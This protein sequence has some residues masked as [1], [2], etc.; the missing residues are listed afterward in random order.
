MKFDIGT[1]LMIG[2]VGLAAFFIYNLVTNCSGAG[3]LGGFGKNICT[4]LHGLIFQNQAEIKAGLDNIQ[5][6]PNQTA[7]LRTASGAHM[8]RLMSYN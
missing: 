7:I 1:I 2:G 3:A 4:S 8:G 6:D 5:S